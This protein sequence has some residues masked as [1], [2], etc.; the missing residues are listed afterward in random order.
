MT[1]LQTLSSMGSDGTVPLTPREAASGLLGSVSMTCW[2]FLLV[3]LSLGLL[4]EVF[5][6][7]ASTRIPKTG[8]KDSSEKKIS[9][10][11]RI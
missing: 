10:Q 11:F 1:L 3:C 6:F 4:W 9:N 2:I 5:A 7:E 8:K